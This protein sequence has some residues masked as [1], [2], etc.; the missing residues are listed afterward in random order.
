MDRLIKKDSEI[1]TIVKTTH[2]IIAARWPAII[3][4]RIRF[5]DTLQFGD[6]GL[7]IQEYFT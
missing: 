5:E 3:R 7:G 1:S 6:H 2:G 4:T